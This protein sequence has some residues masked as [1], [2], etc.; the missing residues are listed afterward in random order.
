MLALRP[1]KQETLR[2][3]CWWTGRS[4]SSGS[5]ERDD[6]EVGGAIGRGIHYRLVDVLVVEAVAKAHQSIVPARRP[7]GTLGNRCIMVS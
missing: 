3:A 1:A 6:G 2:R 5:E 7:H 4:A